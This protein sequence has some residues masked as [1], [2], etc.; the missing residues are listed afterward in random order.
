M[1]GINVFRFTMLIGL[2]CITLMGCNTTGSDVDTE[3]TVD[4]LNQTVRIKPPSEVVEDGSCMANTLSFLVGQ[5]ETALQAMQ[6]PENTRILVHGQVV[7]SIVDP[8]RLNLVIG[9]D[10]NISFVY[11]G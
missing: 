8:S 1:K 3:A 5:P 11:C 10:R 7:N 9:L 2:F 6:Y 4:N